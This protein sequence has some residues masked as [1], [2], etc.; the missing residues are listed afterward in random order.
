[1]D[2]FLTPEAVAAHFKV[3]SATVIKWIKI[4]MLS[5]SHGGVDGGY[6]IS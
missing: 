5:A 1:M 2:C 4:G 3:N 6:S